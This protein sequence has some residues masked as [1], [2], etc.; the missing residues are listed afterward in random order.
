MF[1]LPKNDGK[2]MKR[3][4]D[5]LGDAVSS[6]LDVKEVSDIDS[7]LSG[8]QGN[9]FADEIKGLDDFELIC[10]IVIKKNDGI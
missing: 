8:V 1:N 10:F 9:L 4:S 2:D 5:L 3:Y 6:I 7:F